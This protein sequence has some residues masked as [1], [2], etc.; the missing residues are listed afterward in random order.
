VNAP[1]VTVCMATLNQAEY[2]TQALTSLQAQTLAR[3]RYE[4][5]VIDDGSNDET[6]RLLLEWSPV[7]RLL[8]R[9][10]RGLVA[11][12]NEGLG[13]ARGRYFARVDSDDVVAPNWL[14]SMVTAL[15]E[16]PDACLAYPDR[17][18]I[19]VRSRRRINCNAADIYSLQ[20]CGTVFRT[21]VL[22][23][24]GGFRPFYWEEYDLYLRLRA[25]G[26]WVRVP[27]PLYVCRKHDASMTARASDRINGW[28]QLA[29]EWG[30]DTLRSSGA[31]FE[32][33]QAMA[34]LEGRQSS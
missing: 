33:E 17:I 1:V 20:A 25:A 21:D 11:S 5:V 24:I 15:D 12:C 22:R 13:L 7:I 18:E 29:M 4:V 16:T 10:N 9:D 34:L 23:R 32:M 19:D 28:L 31:E 8:S 14:A 2:L 27:L 3:D 6:P 30:A 26:E